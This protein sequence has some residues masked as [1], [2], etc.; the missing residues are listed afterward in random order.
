MFYLSYEIRVSSPS[1]SCS[2][3]T[4]PA[5][6]RYASGAKKCTSKLSAKR[7][8]FFSPDIDLPTVQDGPANL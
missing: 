4:F 3:G 2:D 5:F 7:L 1:M 6:N 8:K